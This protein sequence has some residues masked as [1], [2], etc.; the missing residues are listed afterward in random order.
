MLNEGF[1]AWPVAYP[2]VPKGQDRVRIVIHAD[3]NPQQ[4][5][6]LVEVIMQWALDQESGQNIEVMKSLL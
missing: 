2:T 1:L 4:I 6:R 3:N 5:E